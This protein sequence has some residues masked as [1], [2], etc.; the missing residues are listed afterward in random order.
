MEDSTARSP[1]GAQL[2]M[3]RPAGLQDGAGGWFYARSGSLI[4]EL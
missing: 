2:G 1:A 4:P 3:P